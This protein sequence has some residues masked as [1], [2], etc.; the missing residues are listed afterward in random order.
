MPPKRSVGRPL[1]SKNKKKTIRKRKA[2]KIKLENTYYATCCNRPFDSELAFIKHKITCDRQI[3]LQYVP[4]KKISLS[5]K[6]CNKKFKF[7]K[8]LQTHYHNEH[9]KL[10][11]AVPCQQCNVRCP[12]HEILDQH[13]QNV[14]EKKEFPCEHC[15]KVFVRHSHVIR[16]MSQTG[17]DGNGHTVFTCEI[18][19]ATFSRKD[20]LQVHLR[21]QHIMRENYW[22]KI[23]IYSTKNFSKLVRHWQNTHM[24]PQVFTCDHCGKS[25]SSRAAISKHLEIHGEKSHICDVCGYSTF[26]TEVLRRH[27]L[28]HVTEKPY[29]C[30]LCGV[31]YIQLSQLRRH[32]EKHKG[33]KCCHCNKTFPSKLKLLIHIREH[34]GLDK[35]VCTFE[36]CSLVKKEFA[37]V[38]TLHAHLKSHVESRS[39]EC[40]VCGKAF[41]S[42]L[43]M[44]RHVSTHRLDR[45][46]R[47]MYCVCARAYV[48]GEQLLRHVRKLHPDIFRQHLQHVRTV[49]GVNPAIERVK[50]SELESILTVL[51]AES[52]RIIESYSDKGVLYGGVQT[53]EERPATAETESPLMSEEDL[54]QNLKILLS[55]LIDMDTLEAFGWQDSSIDEVLEKVVS[56][57]GARAADRGRWAR[58]Q[59]LR[60]NAKLLFLHAGDAA[61][62]RMLD[63]HTIDQIVR[64]VIAQV[65]EGQ[66]RK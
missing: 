19:Q 53:D 20:N 25:T 4:D 66:Q 27:V 57:C 62:A 41:H 29:K 60:E 61:L 32:I 3:S 9:S 48:R 55:H 52:E 43:T 23:C 36:D 28:T 1:G 56:S 24:N 47:C 16:H 65:A 18:C 51:D 34:E 21:L 2:V 11:D 63:S 22:C 39:F 33:N 42:E 58:V 12:T 37:D 40:E 14:H 6:K 49:L 5:C 35:L 54:E 8:S 45:P 38:K 26:T 30:H 46:R 7:K 44:R 64:H 15:G 59:R 10:A 50:K 13:V 17:C 31:S